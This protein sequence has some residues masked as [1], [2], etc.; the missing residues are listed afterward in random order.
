LSIINLEETQTI[1]KALNIPDLIINVNASWGSDKEGHRER[2]LD[3]IRKTKTFFKGLGNSSISHT[4][5]AG[6]YAYA[7][8]DFHIGFDIEKRARVHATTVRRVSVSD[9]E[10]QKARHPE[11]LWVAKEAAFKALR[12]PTQPKVISAIEVVEWVFH[13]TDLETFFIKDPAQ[14]GFNVARGAVLTVDD[15]CLSVF[16]CKNH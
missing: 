11:S 12:G 14:Y 7:P 5:G 10:V 2:I 1:A 9:E 6:G 4:Y 16:I 15:Y 3:D 13:D 8:S